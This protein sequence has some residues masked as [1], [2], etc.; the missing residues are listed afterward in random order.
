MV[1][2]II[3]AAAIAAAFALAGSGLVIAQTQAPQRAEP[4]KAGEV[5]Q[6]KKIAPIPKRGTFVPPKTPW[7]DPDITGDYNNSD[8]SGIP[9]ERPDEY[10]GRTIDSFTPAEL[11]KMIEQRQQQT[12]ERLSL[13]HISEPTRLL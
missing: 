12:I 2:R 13:I 9:F 11:A 4:I 8:E 5:P 6:R 1:R 10:A 7:G 3:T